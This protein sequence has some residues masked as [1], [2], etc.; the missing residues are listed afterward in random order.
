MNFLHSPA[1]LTGTAA[2]VAQWLPQ[3]PLLSLLYFMVYG[4][5]EEGVRAG[6][7]RQ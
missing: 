5:T 4:L 2:H 1:S 3:K 7:H 6:P